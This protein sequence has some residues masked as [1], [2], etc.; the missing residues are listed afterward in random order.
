MTA[1]AIVIVLIGAFTGGF[2]SGLAGFGTGLIALGIWLHVLEPAPATTLVLVCSVVAQ[3]LTFHAIRK[4]VRWEKVWPFV[5]F[6][7]V[8]V[9]FGTWALGHFDPGGFKVVVGIFLIAF[10]SFLLLSRKPMHLKIGGWPIEGAVGFI[11]GV[12]GGLAGLSGPPP[13]IWATLKGWTKEE[14]RAV[15]QSFNWTVLFCSLIAHAATGFVDKEV[16]VLTLIA[17]PGTIIGSQ[18]GVRAYKRLSDKNFHQIILV[19][20]LFSGVTLVWSAFS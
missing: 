13:I 3:T 14:R 17:L 18:I 11:G 5:V 19:L 12:L 7:V 15:F 10:S 2:V 9:P 4:S 1:A 20:L 8:G 6:G 16:G